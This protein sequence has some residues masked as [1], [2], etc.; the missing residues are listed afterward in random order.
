[1]LAITTWT[2]AVRP[3]TPR[4]WIARAPISTSIDGAKPAI[5]E[6]IEK[7]TSAR[8]HQELLAEQVGE[9]APDRGGRRHGQQRG[10]DDP[11]VAGLAA[12][13]VGDDRGSALETTVLESIATN[14]AS[15]SPLRASRTSRWVIC[16]AGSAG[17]VRGA[18]S[19]SLGSRQGEGCRGQLYSL[20]GDIP[21][22]RNDPQA[23][24]ALGAAAPEDVVPDH[25]R[26]G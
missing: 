1:M 8:L 7:M 11:R 22:M 25:L 10:D 19:W 14:I 3:P 20:S 18:G 23:W 4:P 17:R 6:P 12:V 21:E 24:P 15:S 2:S 5:S 16:P 9:L 13:E 26:V